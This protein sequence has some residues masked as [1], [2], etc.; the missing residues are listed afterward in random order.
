MH[1]VWPERE[2]GGLAAAA[3]GVSLGEIQTFDEMAA[4]AWFS[5]LRCKKGVYGVDLKAL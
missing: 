4:R 5:R 1:L 3:D 2:Q